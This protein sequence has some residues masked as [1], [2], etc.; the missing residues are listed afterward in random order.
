MPCPYHNLNINRYQ[1]YQNEL[2]NIKIKIQIE[3]FK[4]A[5]QGIFKLLVCLDC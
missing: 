5:I 2:H 4:I 3:G 1:L